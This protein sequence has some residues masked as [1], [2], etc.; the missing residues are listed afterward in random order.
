MRQ[1]VEAGRGQVRAFRDGDRSEV[2]ALRLV[3]GVLAAS[4]FAGLLIQLLTNDGHR[5]FG[6][7][8]LLWGWRGI[9][10]GNFPYIDR[11]LEYP[12]V[13]GYLM[14]LVSFVSTNATTFLLA[15]SVVLTGFGAV[16]T[17]ALHQRVGRRALLFA[18]APTLILYSFHNWD[19]VPVA[20]TVTGLLALERKRPVL[21]SFL[22]SMGAWS[23]LYPGLFLPVIAVLLW[24]EGDREGARKVVITAAIT[25]AVLNV[26]IMVTAW[27]GWSWAL[28]FQGDRRASSGSFW[29][30]FVHFPGFHGNALNTA[31]WANRTS[32]LAM[33]VG[34]GVVG[35]L[36]IRNRVSPIAAAAAITTVFILSNK[37]FSPQYTLWVVPFFV[38]LPIARKWWALLVASDA[39]MYLPL[40]CS[41]WFP[42]PGGR[43]DR[44]LR[45]DLMLLFAITRAVALV[46][47]I[48]YS[49]RKPD[50]VDDAELQALAAGDPVGV[51][52]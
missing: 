24:R 42:G 6:D 50:D 43:L 14:W 35:L 13:I 11:D 46:A 47:L 19:L 23:K 4:L 34:L 39:L 38:L 8:G 32:I 21:G 17:V 27:G 2:Q 5:S 40:F 48:V 37:I 28:H 51:T 3:L 25:S 16:T 44:H 49:L 12:V 30:S 15:N 36:A 1:V 10:P 33:V 9:R 7:I 52:T 29:Y 31:E 41:T 45:D 22:L 26:P 20:L 18:G